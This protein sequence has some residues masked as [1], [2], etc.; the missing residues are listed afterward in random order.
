MVNRKLLAI[1][2]NSEMKSSSRLLLIML[3][4]LADHRGIVLGPRIK[5][6]SN[7]TGLSV[8]AVRAATTELRELGWIRS[9]ATKHK[10]NAAMSGPNRYLIHPDLLGDFLTGIGEEG[11]AVLIE[12]TRELDAHMEQTIMFSELSPGRIVSPEEKEQEGE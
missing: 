9:Q 11:R 10:N 4:D 3:T 5:D 2:R 8:T 1:T 6:L 12:R 7:W